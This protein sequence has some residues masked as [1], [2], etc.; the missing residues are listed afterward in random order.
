MPTWTELQEYARSKYKLADDEERWFAVVF[1]EGKG[2]TQ[3]IIVTRF[4]AFRRDWVEFRTPVC[5]SDE[6]AP[7]VALRKN[8]EMSLGF[9]ALAKDMYWLLHT[10]SLDTLDTAEFELPL[11]Y[12][13]TVADSL[14]QQ[15]SGGNDDY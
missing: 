13:T 11:E 14:E 8:A 7:I 15:H 5:R 4:T 1:R 10:A 2:R 9:L 6:M 3:K 12:L